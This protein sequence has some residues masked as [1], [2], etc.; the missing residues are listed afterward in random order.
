MVYFLIL[1]TFNTPGVNGGSGGDV[2]INGG[3]G[4]GLT[5]GNVVSDRHRRCVTVDACRN[6]IS[7]GVTW[8]WI[9]LFRAVMLR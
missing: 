5:G 6:I 4:Y 8:L 3:V 7:A 9:F 2:Q 1:G